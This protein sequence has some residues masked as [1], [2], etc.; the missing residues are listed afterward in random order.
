MALRKAL[1]GQPE[2][3][4]LDLLRGYSWS[5]RLYHRDPMSLIIQCEYTLAKEGALFLSLC[6]DPWP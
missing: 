5:V 2:A 4:D 6:S 1:S 3:G